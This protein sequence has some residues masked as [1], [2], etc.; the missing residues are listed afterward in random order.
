MKSIHKKTEK[1]AAARNALTFPMV[2]LEQLKNGKKV[3]QVDLDLAV[4]SL[5]NVEK[6]ILSLE[7]VE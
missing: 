3:R 1:I 7:S 6:V 2:V 5:K 4:K